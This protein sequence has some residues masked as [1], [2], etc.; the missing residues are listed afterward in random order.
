MS[1]IKRGQ[2]RVIT[3]LED[4]PVLI[5]VTS[6]VNNDLCRAVT[7]NCVVTGREVS[8]GLYTEGQQERVGPPLNEMEVIAWAA[9]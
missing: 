6:I 7:G 9:K 3:L 8:H 4:P 2:F 5:E 1:K